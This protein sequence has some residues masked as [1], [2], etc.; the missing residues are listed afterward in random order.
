M[1]KLDDSLNLYS[2]NKTFSIRWGGHKC[3]KPASILYNDQ[4]W[5]KY[6]WLTAKFVQQ[7]RVK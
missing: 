5:K 4:Y 2:I 7:L 3:N 1:A 6:F